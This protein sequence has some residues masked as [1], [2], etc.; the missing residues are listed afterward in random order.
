DGAVADAEDQLVAFL[1]QHLGPADVVF[2][3]WAEDGHSD[4]EAVGRA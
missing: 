1:E 3:T 2:A 4:H